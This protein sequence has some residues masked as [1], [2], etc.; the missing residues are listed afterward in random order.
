MINQEI[1]QISDLSDS[2]SHGD[3]HNVICE[4]AFL[5][6][7]LITWDSALLFMDDVMVVVIFRLNYDDV[8]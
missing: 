3:S 5:G 6:I 8:T 1:Y 7:S 4:Q 2:Q